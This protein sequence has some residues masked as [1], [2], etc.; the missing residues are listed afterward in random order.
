MQRDIYQFLFI[1][2]NFAVPSKRYLVIDLELNILKR[3][4]EFLA[5]II[6]IVTC[7]KFSTCR[8]VGVNKQDIWNN[9][10]LSKSILYH[11]N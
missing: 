10:M 7:W 6:K 1:N 4:S 3:L 2:N 8:I 9:Q 11:P 5:S